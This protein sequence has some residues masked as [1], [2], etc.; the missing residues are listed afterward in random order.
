[1][2]I[3]EIISSIRKH[4]ELEKLS[5]V[6]EYIFNSRRPSGYGPGNAKKRGT[7]LC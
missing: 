4:I 1:M 6:E 3:N 7:F 5:G 2:D